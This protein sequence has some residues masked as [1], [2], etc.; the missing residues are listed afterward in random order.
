VAIGQGRFN[1]HTFFDAIMREPKLA[2]PRQIS[3]RDNDRARK[4]HESQDTISE[5]DRIGFIWVAKLGQFWQWRIEKVNVELWTLG[6]GYDHRP[7]RV[8]HRIQNIAER[9]YVAGHLGQ[10]SCD[11]P[12][13]CLLPLKA[14]IG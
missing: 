13:H 4:P 8:W 11:A 6:R 9:G 10:K 2:E 1:H 7:V 12:L 14:Q 3:V 5:Q